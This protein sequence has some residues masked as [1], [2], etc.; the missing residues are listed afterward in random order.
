MHQP[1]PLA[2]EIDVKNRCWHEMISYLYNELLPLST[3]YIMSKFEST[4][5]VV[6]LPVILLVATSC[7]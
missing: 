3:K 7:C 5:K 4:A 6:I 1:L 2:D